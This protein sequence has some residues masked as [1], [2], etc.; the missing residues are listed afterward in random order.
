MKRRLSIVDDMAMSQLELG[1][2]PGGNRSCSDW[3]RMMR[4]YLRM[5]QMELAHRAGISQA[6]IGA[7]ESGS[8]MPRIDTLVKVF[9]ALYCQVNIAPRP[10]KPLNEILRGRARSVALKRLKQSMGT[11]ALEKQA[12]DKE[13]FRQLLEKQTDEILSDH[14]ERL[15]DGPNDEF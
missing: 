4:I 3:I 8:I 15:W 6:H 7:I 5:T 1:S 12:P 9:N 13:V 11:M 10:K 2:I 14:K